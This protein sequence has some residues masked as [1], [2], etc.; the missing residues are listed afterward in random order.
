MLSSRTVSSMSDEEVSLL[1]S[2]SVD[3]VAERAR[4]DAT[5]NELELALGPF[6]KQRAAKPVMD[7]EAPEVAQPT[8]NPPSPSQKSCTDTADNDVFWTP[9]VESNIF[10][11]AIDAI[12]EMRLKA[13]SPG[14]SF[15]SN[16]RTP[17][18]SRPVTRESMEDHGSPLSSV[19]SYDSQPQ[20]CGG[21][22]TP[23][24]AKP[25]LGEGK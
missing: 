9:R 20:D 16:E 23:S 8:T 18:S 22:T 13:G 12:S 1:A 4:L 3:I 11:S 21:V 5:I 19:T 24:T 10:F 25:S 14:P 15:V 17:Q 2:E 7:F 6:E